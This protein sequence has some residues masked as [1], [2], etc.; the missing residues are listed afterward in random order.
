MGFRLTL[1]TQ[2]FFGH[3]VGYAY[4]RSHLKLQGVDQGGM[5]I[6]Q[7]FCGGENPTPEPKSAADQGK[8]DPDAGGNGGGSEPSEHGG[9]HTWSG[10]VRPGH[11]P[12]PWVTGADWSDRC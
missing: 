5:A 11:R 3:E 1:N 2:K 9:L 10:C 6:H 4:N 12:F 7:G 8:C